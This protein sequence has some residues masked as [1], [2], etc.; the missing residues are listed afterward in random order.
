MADRAQRFV[1]GVAESNAPVAPGE[2]PES[3][4][5]APDEQTTCWACGK[6]IAPAKAPRALCGDCAYGGY[7]GA[8]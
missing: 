1:G 4:L 5:A 3:R 6:E 7:M 2:V 8:S